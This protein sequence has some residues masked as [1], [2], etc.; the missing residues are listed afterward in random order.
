MQHSPFSFLAIVVHRF[1]LNNCLPF[2]FFSHT[3]SY[4]PHNNWFHDSFLLF[5]SHQHSTHSSPPPPLWYPAHRVQH[6]LSKCDSWTSSTSIITW[7]LVRNAHSPAPS[8]IFWTRNFWWVLMIAVYQTLQV[9]ASEPVMNVITR[10]TSWKHCFNCF[11][12]SD[13]LNGS[14]FLT[15]LSLILSTS[16]LPVYL[17]STWTPCFLT[18]LPFH[19]TPLPT[20]STLTHIL[21]VFSC[22]AQVLFL[23]PARV[24]SST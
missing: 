5:D 24:F 3:Y 1:D 14:P 2:S 18:F 22:I 10:V 21:C 20:L 16:T 13:I 19:A 6:C 7:E 15:K 9:R 23:S 4:L 17:C 11:F 12:S 8:Q